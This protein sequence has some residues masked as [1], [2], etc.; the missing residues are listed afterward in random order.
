MGPNTLI[1][2]YNVSRAF[3]HGAI[4]LYILLKNNFNNGTSSVAFF[5]NER[6]L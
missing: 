2:H 4:L 3:K 6:C 5:E 1:L